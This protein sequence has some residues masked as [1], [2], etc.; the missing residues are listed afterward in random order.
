MAVS[1]AYP[2]ARIRLCAGARSRH[3]LESRPASS[4][5]PCILQATTANPANGNSIRGDTHARAFYKKHQ[6][7]NDNDVE[8]FA[9][10]IH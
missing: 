10:E 2:M 1:V 3:S 6:G 4:H 5:K 7:R 9:T 8:H